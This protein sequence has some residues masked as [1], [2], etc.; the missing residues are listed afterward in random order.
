MQKTLESSQKQHTER[1]QVG[2]GDYIRDSED[3]KHQRI[4]S[5]IT[6]LVTSS[7]APVSLNDL[8]SLQNEVGEKWE[9]DG[10][11]NPA[12]YLSETG[13]PVM[14]ARKPIDPT[15]D[16]PRE[17]RL[18]V[19]GSVSDVA[20]PSSLAPRRLVWR[21][22][23]PWSLCIYDTN[24][25]KTDSIPE[26]MLPLISKFGDALDI[27]F[28]GASHDPRT[29]QR[30]NNTY[31]SLND[32]IKERERQKE[33]YDSDREEAYGIEADAKSAAAAVRK[34]LFMTARKHAQLQDEAY[35]QAIHNSYRQ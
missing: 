12:M 17:W 9:E 7:E 16:S 22:G 19:D 25:A 27:N 18:L 35:K 6:E 21:N 4:L 30:L 14:I 33:A 26:S 29:P 24:G 5:E 2:S 8:E 34:K 20:V 3:I 11:G 28:P 23:S 15:S 1:I 10:Y 13:E 32:V 31:Y